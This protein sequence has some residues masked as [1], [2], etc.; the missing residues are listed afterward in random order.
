MAEKV[1]IGVIGCGA[2]ARYTH[3]H[4]YAQLD[5][6]EVVALAD[7]YRKNLN[8][9]GDMHNIPK[10]ARYVS[11]ED[12]LARDDIDA[13]SVCT[14]NYLHGPQ[15]VDA[16]RAGKH[17]LCEKPMATSVEAAEAMVNAAA[18]AKKVLMVGFTHR[19]LKH[20][21]V[22]K[23][24]LEDGAIGN[25]YMIRV[26]FAHDGPYK[27]WAATTDWFFRPEKAGGGALLDMG[28]HALDISRYMLGEITSI[29]GR[30]GTFGKD[31][32]VEDTAVLNF[33]FGDR[34]LGYIE[35]GWSSKEGVLG[36]EIYGTEGTIVVDY[37]TPI[38][39]FRASTGQ[40]EE[41]TD[42]KN[43]AA[44]AEM[45]H[46]VDC[47][48]TGKTPLTSGIDGLISVKLAAAVYESAKTGCS[49]CLE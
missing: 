4:G 8:L 41:I 42:A 5:D 26:R 46:F 11:Y 33:S 36:L 35:T 45:R 40:W 31:I 2:I 44:V 22:A 34:A 38:R 12:L 29:S 37:V 19:Y 28:I 48:K 15:T 30:I 32:V 10:D 14:P 23:G 13:V 9:L 20:N 39:V 3:L 16:L 6:V 24:L 18:D 1:K 17:V 27:S 49:V 7:P 43:D 25:P 21:Q 47:V